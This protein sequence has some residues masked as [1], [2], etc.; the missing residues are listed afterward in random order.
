M[1]L[2]ASPPTVVLLL[3][4]HIVNTEGACPSPAWW[5]AA[6][7]DA[8]SDIYLGYDCHGELWA[9]HYLILSHPAGEEMAPKTNGGWSFVKR[10]G[11]GLSPVMLGHSKL[12]SWCD[13]RSLV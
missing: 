2:E 13:L 5:V 7:S 3:E 4:R 12:E 6:L 8:I 1:D 11:P 10:S 9:M